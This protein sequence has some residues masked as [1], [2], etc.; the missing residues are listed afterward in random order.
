MIRFER[1]SG[2][3]PFVWAFMAPIDSTSDPQSLQVPTLP[4][5]YYGPETGQQQD[6]FIEVS[7]VEGIDWSA[8]DGKS[9]MY[10]LGNDARAEWRGG[11]FTP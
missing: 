10:E 5:G 7:I 6:Y 4:G 1:M 9:M 3:E 8:W 11:Y 2:A